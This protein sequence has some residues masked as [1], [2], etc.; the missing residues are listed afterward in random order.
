MSSELDNQLPEPESE[1]DRAYA[2]INGRSRQDLH[3]IVHS[4]FAGLANDGVLADDISTIETLPLVRDGREG[5]DLGRCAILWCEYLVRAYFAQRLTAKSE[6]TEVFRTERAYAPIYLW[7][8]MKRKIRTLIRNSDS[9]YSSLKR[10]SWPYV[11][12]SPLIITRTISQAMT[13]R[14]Q[15]RPSLALTPISAIILLSLAGLGKKTFR[16]RISGN[17]YRLFS[18]RYELFY[19]RSWRLRNISFGLTLR[20]AL[21]G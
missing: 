2:N 7:N 21:Y 18:T 3:R 15:L 13:Q 11:N 12:E 5:N 16:E 17:T 4:I 14:M 1:L 8:E 19:Y 10:P 20:R 6:M 9:S